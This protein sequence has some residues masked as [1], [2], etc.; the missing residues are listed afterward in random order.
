MMLARSFSRAVRTPS[1][2]VSN[3][4]TTRRRAFFPSWFENTSECTTDGYLSRSNPANPTSGC[5]ASSCLTNPPTKPITITLLRATSSAPRRF[6]RQTRR[7]AACTLWSALGS[8]HTLCCV[9]LPKWMLASSLNAFACPR[10]DPGC[11]RPMAAKIRDNAT[12]FLYSR[13]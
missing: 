3:S 4:C 11:A 8:W 1:R 10:A 6:L 13:T 12:S 9:A 7:S 5:L 2:F